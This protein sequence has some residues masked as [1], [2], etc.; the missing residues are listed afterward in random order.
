M[1]FWSRLGDA[2]KATGDALQNGIALVQGNT[3]GLD[4]GSAATP[5]HATFGDEIRGVYADTVSKHG[6][7]DDEQAKQWSIAGHLS[8]S[9]DLSS[10][11]G[12]TNAATTV[13]T[14]AVEPLM[15]NDFIGPVMQKGA[16]YFQAAD[17]VF[18]AV[19]LYDP[20]SKAIGID[21]PF[22][23]SRKAWDNAW[24]AADRETG[25]GPNGAALLFENYTGQLDGRNNPLNHK[26]AAKELKD[27]Y[28]N[29]WWGVGAGVAD[30]ILLGA[31]DPTKGIGR[32]AKGARA[33]TRLSTPGKAD[34]VAAKLNSAANAADA[35]AGVGRKVTDT[36]RGTF[37]FGASA[38]GNT[39]E[40]YKA[41]RATH[42]FEAVDL[43]N[44]Y[45]PL[46]QSTGQANSMPIL[47]LMART[48]RIL[49]PHEQAVVKGNILLAA[50]GSATARAE[51]I[52]SAP[53]L[54]AGLQR[55]TNAP[56]YFAHLD[57]LATKVASQPGYNM[58]AVRQA[59]ERL[60]MDPA[61]KAELKAYTKD[62]D[63][64]QS[65]FDA[66]DSFSG[67]GANAAS[68]QNAVEIGMTAL[69]RAK[70]SM[71]KRSSFVYQNGSSGA[72]VTYLQWSTRDKNMGFVNVAEPMVGVDHLTSAL[73]ETKLYTNQ[74]IRDRAN[75]F[76]GA[77]NQQGRRH[78]AESVLDGMVT[79]LG[80]KYNLTRDQMNIITADLSAARSHATQYL[81]AAAA[82]A[83]QTGRT[84]VFHDPGYT[85]KIAVNR[86][87][88]ETHIEKSV[89]IPPV[90]MLEDAIKVY[91]RE[92]SMGD[93]AGAAAHL[94]NE[95]LQQMTS[96]WRF[97]VLAR[98]GL[99]VR[100]MADVGL[101]ATAM[102]G[103]ANMF[104]NT[105]HGMNDQTRRVL[106]STAPRVVPLDHAGQL[107]VDQMT[108]RAAELRAKGLTTRADELEQQ[109]Q[110]MLAAGQVFRADRK[111][112]TK[113]TTVRLAGQR[114]TFRAYG[115]EGSLKGIEHAVVPGGHQL[116]ES[117]APTVGRRVDKLVEDNE[118]WTTA[119]P[120]H[121]YWT[122][123]Y[124]RSMD[125]LRT[126]HTGNRVLSESSLP[127]T[128]DLIG[129]LRKDA[130][131]RA[132]WQNIKDAHPNLN[133]W[134]EDMVNLV[135]FHAP[136]AE[137]KQAVLGERIT[138]KQIDSLFNDANGAGG[139]WDRMPVNGPGVSHAT[140]R[141][142]VDQF[143]KFQASMYRNLLDK[144]D[145]HLVRMPLYK[146]QFK[147]HVRDQ[148]KAMGR[149]GARHLNGEDLARIEANARHRA[150]Q[151]VRRVMVNTM[152]TT[153]AMET[154]RVAAPFLA[155]WQDAMESW[156]RLMYDDPAVIGKWTRYWQL[157]AQ[158]GLVVDQDGKII[159]PWED[160]S[161]EGKTKMINV[162]L[163]EGVKNLTGLQDVRI[164]QDSLN[165]AWQG[166][167]PWMPGF[168]P[169]VAVP[170]AQIVGH[171]MPE[172]G[173]SKNPILKSLFP[174]GLPEGSNMAGSLGG[175]MANQFLPAWARAI[176]NG[177]S[178]QTPEFGRA[179][180]T[181]LNG[182]IVEFTNKN[183]RKPTSDELAPLQ[184]RARKAVK[185]ALVL[186]GVA[187]G[188]FGISTTNDVRGQFYVE[189]MQQLYT[190]EPQLHAKGYTVTEAF[191]FMFPEAADMDWSATE[192]KTGITYTMKA[193]NAAQ[194]YKT[195]IDKNPEYG[196]FY[197]GAD[198]MGGEFS[199]TANALQKGNL[200]GAD[201]VHRRVLT[202]A[203]QDRKLEAE[204]G[205]AE[206]R[207]F[208]TAAQVELEKRGLHSMSQKGA[209][210]IV[211]LR[212]NLKDKLAV[213]YPEWGKEQLAHPSSAI[214]K[215]EPVLGQ[216]L[217]DPRLKK[218][219]DVRAIA[220]YMALRQQTLDLLKNNKG[221]SADL[222]DPR[223][224]DVTE[225]LRQQGE[226][227]S[228]Q[229]FGF[230]QAWQRLF[231]R[232]VE[233]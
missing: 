152:R 109:A 22:N 51:L 150:I 130:R 125:A 205:W 137:I 122:E 49:D 35:T 52:K 221:R 165:T 161:S 66:L 73:K 142:P 11:N 28:T 166:E 231:S 199:A 47:A 16:E 195:Q 176:R 32:I 210:D 206:Y 79:R 1:S 135:D 46:L 123:K 219:P 226:L 140:G 74:E 60:N 126:S 223:N 104:L 27:K 207:K 20:A 70:A 154:M 184:E 108:T 230:Q 86:A 173:D 124:I 58:A 194:R 33:A 56:A 21:S 191:N 82:D 204:L 145:V 183:G 14:G 55:I 172:L 215:F 36:A 177:L 19:A 53:Q 134:I 189:Q 100:A 181:A 212:K 187:L 114:H 72:T 115:D 4:G 133:A 40:L 8:Q 26:D 168:G 83:A 31:V 107:R 84:V 117:Y 131:V 67:H 175:Q 71:R 43:F 112:A 190:M 92:W 209:R 201:K 220:Q 65:H 93:S 155:P 91:K 180:G 178:Q 121:P 213:E 61:S 75:A 149:E 3:V 95:K 96:L 128:H 80:A 90:D 87:L 99:A 30:T 138:A 76:I 227:L 143:K 9:Y 127:D 225:Y 39:S 169:A 119:M 174:F 64:L 15:E 136:T 144:P 192:N 179:Y 85:S 97:M 62:I 216:A 17:H 170:A 68:A 171:L 106:G 233:G 200:Y 132:E 111:A 38:A 163:P 167:V 118:N 7:I 50:R 198:N 164:R 211:A 101:R 232:E 196:W 217:N 81:S 69:D 48:N 113:G 141:N 37:G 13:A 105:V 162:P 193:E 103:A 59:A 151:D 120:D 41:M 208:A 2:L 229:N 29:S 94:A 148:V 24:A 78:V 34:E 139:K 23:F 160:T 54:A 224:A 44:H 218:R 25:I 10:P 222:N 158:A 98:P 156:A 157:P 12:I 146:A 110:D 57:D 18:G 228:R 89:V 42:G 188:L 63:N 102:A 88:L 116:H 203:E 186:K 182:N 77:G 147:S 197:T 153:G 214:E 159:H 45:G 129:S 202:P 185:T 6:V 5:G